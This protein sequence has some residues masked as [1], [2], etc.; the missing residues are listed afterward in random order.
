MLFALLAVVRRRPVL[1]LGR[2]VLVNEA[3]PFVEALTRVPLDRVA[4][5]TTGGTARRL[6][7]DGMLFDQT[8]AAHR[9]TRRAVAEDLGTAGVARLRPVWSAVLQRRLAPLAD[10]G[11]VDLVD[12]VAEMTGATTAALLGLSVDPHALS[13]AA[14][15]AAA[16]A[17]RDHLPGLPRPG[18]ARRART[19]AARLTELVRAPDDP[20]G[21]A[22]LLAVASVNTTLAAVPR[23][24]AWCADDRLWD[25][26]ADDL[27]RPLLVTELLRVTAA[28]PLLPRV[29]AGPGTVGG[30]PVRRGDRL[31][32]V[33]RHAVGAHRA[34]PDC[35]AP[36]PAQLAQL[37]FGAGPHACPGA[38]L[39]RA[40]LTDV[41]AGLAPHRPVVVAARVDR[42][43]ALPGWAT[44]LIRAEPR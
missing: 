27:T 5:G 42:R 12:V 40:Q 36:A 3:Q 21:G 2:T 23:A 1:R 35:A 34:D 24:V 18:R 38:H 4:A 41:L 22:A 16:A 37:V 17:A 19:T 31:L 44:L 14:R 29:A 20:T 11:T 6:D 10:G 28:S 7:A 15:A 43:S 30:A 13:S 26:A 8:G 33:A 32:L 39:A 9:S 25:R